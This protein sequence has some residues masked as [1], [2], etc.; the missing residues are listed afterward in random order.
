[1]RR[2]GSKVKRR[3]LRDMDNAC[4]IETIGGPGRSEG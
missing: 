4:P 1:M 3:T 2:F